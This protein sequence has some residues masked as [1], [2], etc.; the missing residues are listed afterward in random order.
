M[1]RRPTLTQHDGLFRTTRYVLYG[2]RVRVIRLS[3][4]VRDDQYIP[5]SA[6]DPDPC[7]V[8]APDLRSAA[9]SLLLF[10]PALAG[11]SGW[12][13]PMNAVAGIASLLLAICGGALLAR[14]AWPGRT[15]VQHGALQMVADQPDAQTFRHFESRLI[16]ATRERLLAESES[17]AQ[18]EDGRVSLAREIRR[19]H[20]HCTQGHLTSE[21][22]ARQKSRLIARIRDFVP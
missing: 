20:E 15:Y 22:F 4:L 7:F 3:P 17:G 16:T 2:N 5:M 10:V 8:R 1:H 21:A 18:D 14:R 6:V 19:L 12:P 11:L 13:E 9:L